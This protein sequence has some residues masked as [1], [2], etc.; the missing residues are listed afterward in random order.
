M[1]FRSFLL[2]AAAGATPLLTQPQ[3]AGW[4]ALA[5]QIPLATLVLVQSYM[6]QRLGQ[7]ERAAWARQAEHLSK[8]CHDTQLS[9][10]DS[11]KQIGQ[12]CHA[13]HER[14]EE[15]LAEAVRENAKVLGEMK[16][17]LLNCKMRR[18]T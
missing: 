17:V 14:R 4:L 5:M 2:L 13:R 8:T 7:K 18:I 11:I 15:L 12:D 9:F 16:E 10:A 6:N 1:I 3:G